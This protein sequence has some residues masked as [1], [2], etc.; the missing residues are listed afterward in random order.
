MKL[1]KIANINDFRNRLE[2]EYSYSMVTER[3]MQKMEELY[4]TKSRLSRS[5]KRQVRID[6]INETKDEAKRLT[7]EIISEIES[8]GV[9]LKFA[10]F[11]N[12]AF[13]LAHQNAL[14]INPVIMG[15][16]ID[17]I[18]FILF[19]EL[20]HYAQYKKYGNDFAH[21]VYTGNLD[22]SV[23]KLTHIEAV[24][25]RLGFQ[26]MNYFINKYNIVTRGGIV[27]QMMANN[28]EDNIRNS[29]QLVRQ[30]VEKLPE[31]QRSIVQINDLIYNMMSS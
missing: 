7:D 15:Y 12:K 3:Q 14:Y 13:G 22:E 17:V 10:Q 26:K 6:A 21:S 4:K 29:L 18:L 5:E 16:G 31:G 19:H 2:E 1:I 8:I 24:A 23:K 9:P 30:E 27:N 11:G 20:T 25:N 28:S